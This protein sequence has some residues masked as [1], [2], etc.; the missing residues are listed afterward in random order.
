MNWHKDALKSLTTVS[1]S[2]FLSTLASRLI[3]NFEFIE[4]WAI[5]T[6]LILFLSLLSV[7]VKSE[8]IGENYW[9]YN[10]RRKFKTP[11]IGIL[12][13]VQCENSADGHPYTSFFAN[14]WNTDLRRLGLNSELITIDQ[15]SDRYA[16]VID[17]YGEVYLERDPILLYSFQK[18]KEYV[19]RGGIFVCAGGVAF[20]YCWDSRTQHRITLSKIVQPFVQVQQNIFIPQFFYPPSYSLVDILV[21][22]HFGVSVLGDTQRPPSAPI[23]WQ[24]IFQT[25]QA[26]EDIQYVGDLSQVGGTN[27]VFVFRPVMPITRSCIPFLRANVPNFGEVYPIA[28][29]PYERGLLV[30]CG[31]DLS[32]NARVGNINIARGEF[33]K[34]C[35]TI[36]N[37]LN[38]IRLNAISYD[39]R[40][41]R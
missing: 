24:P 33:E 37:I 26:N 38:G 39:W 11:A 4:T 34:I 2:V 27:Q 19:S 31:V 1:L 23:G 5:I 13:E 29:I 18:I 41:R 14:D 28:G 25:Q 17:P 30:V 15:L 8:W 16:V 3:F 20:F 40:R 22:E 12:H 35:S 7:T 6:L 10:M 21:N 9:N 36:A 32:T